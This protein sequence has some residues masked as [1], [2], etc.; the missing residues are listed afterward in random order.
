MEL[1]QS[2]QLLQGARNEI[3]AA[4]DKLKASEDSHKQT[5]IE[6]RQSVEEGREQ[7]KEIDGLKGQLAQTNGKSQTLTNRV[8]ELEDQL[9]RARKLIVTIDD[10]LKF[11]KKLKMEVLRE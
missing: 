4:R 5:K 9:A 8:A 6:L 11:E 3:M 7:Q 2:M 10:E 1:G